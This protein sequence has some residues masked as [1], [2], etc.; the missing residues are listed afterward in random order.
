MGK[1]EQMVAAANE[2][3]RVANERFGLELALK[4]VLQ[5]RLSL[6]GGIAERL[7]ELAKDRDIDAFLYELWRPKTSHGERNPLLDQHI[8]S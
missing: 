5:G 1:E 6:G 2:L 7:V 8:D 3:C 4:C